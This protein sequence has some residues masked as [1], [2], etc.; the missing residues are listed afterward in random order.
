ME[1]DIL[2]TPTYKV[3]LKGNRFVDNDIK[4]IDKINVYLF[5]SLYNLI[6]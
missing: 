2:F 6:S 5:S 4:M 1:N 3:Q